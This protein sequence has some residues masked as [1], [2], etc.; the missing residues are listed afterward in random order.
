MVTGTEQMPRRARYLIPRDL[1]RRGEILAALALAAALAHLLLAQLTLVLAV[2]FYGITKATRWRL[3]WLTVPAALGAVWALAAGPAAAAAGF[4]AG[5]RQVIG[6]LSASGHEVSHLL[7]PGS[8][9]SGTGGWLPRQFPIA[10]IAGA[11]EAA[12]AGW[13]GWLHTDEWAVA[14]PRPGLLAA[15]RRAAV[16][17]SV[18]A[19]AII[20]RDGVCLGVVPASGDRAGL[21]WREVTGGVLFAGAA[22]PDVAATS[23]QLVHA[24]LRRRKPV[25]AVDLTADPVIPRALA[26]VCAAAGTELQVFGD[27]AAGYY[28]PFRSGDPAHRASLVLAMISLDGPASQYRNSC[29]AYL[30][31]V[32]ELL[33]AAPGDPLTPVLDDVIHLLNPLALQAR[34]ACVPL[35]HPRRDALAERI[36]VSARLVQ[37]EPQ[38]VSALARQLGELRASRAGQWLGP[39]GGEPD[40]RIDLGR[41]V[42]ERTAALFPVGSDSRAAGVARAVARDI[43]TACAE[44]RRIGVDGDGI[45]WLSGCEHLPSRVTAELAR[46]GAASGLPVLITTTAAGAATEL[47]GQMNALVIHQ[48][49]DIEA[50]RSLAARTGQRLV[51]ATPSGVPVPAAVS[52]E[53]SADAR[54]GV[55]PPQPPAPAAGEW[56]ALAARPAVGPQEL[57]VLRR[58]EFVLVV[59]GPARRLVP[60]AQA[61]PARLPVPAPGT[62]GQP[63]WL[64]RRTAV[65]YG[66]VP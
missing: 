42:R 6:Y 46:A 22:R 48:L 37:A 56:P 24:A 7:H 65:S 26:A 61:L 34:M 39:G 41:V 59:N 27:G 62:A 31:D 45:V 12:L 35:V 53:T 18:R 8:A 36:R 14:P 29:E 5:P 25:I 38:V 21:A 63:R 66:E 23:F 17:R 43:L 33:D 19:G 47:A 15:L 50:A 44:L 55:P 1:P 52:A 11:A 51:P 40:A 58:G 30:L 60:L 13:L 2:L 54:P 9:F 20:T 64:V 57:R 16:R 32:F 4:A 49:S 10:L 3:W 28:E